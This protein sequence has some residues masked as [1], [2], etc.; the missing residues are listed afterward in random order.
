MT[1]T[2]LDVPLLRAHFQRDVL[3][4]SIMD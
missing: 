2:V 4:G 3:Q 1:F